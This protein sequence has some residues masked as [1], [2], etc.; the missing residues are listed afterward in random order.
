MSDLTEVKALRKNCCS[1]FSSRNNPEDNRHK[2]RCF[3]KID[4]RTLLTFCLPRLL[5]RCLRRDTKARRV[6]HVSVRLFS[7][8]GVETGIARWVSIHSRHL[9]PLAR[10]LQGSI[11]PANASPVI[12][13]SRK[14]PPKPQ[15]PSEMPPI[16]RQEQR[17]PHPLARGCVIE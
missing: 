6:E 5:C 17:S 16:M 15:H 3:C 10:S 4:A 8:D 2:V 11:P 9:E 7:T 1:P 12:D 14:A 13:T